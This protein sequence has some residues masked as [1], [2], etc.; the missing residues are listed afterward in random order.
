MQIQLTLWYRDFSRNRYFVRQYAYPKSDNE[1]L[2]LDATVY[3]RVKAQ[4]HILKISRTMYERIKMI[5][6][7]T[8]KTLIHDSGLEESTCQ[9]QFFGVF[10]NYVYVI[11]LYLN[12]SITYPR[13]ITP[14]HMTNLRHS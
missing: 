13:Q 4:I 5:W 9:T 11:L 1:I 10:K 2:H 12:G 6:K 7:K 8:T 3:E 14:R